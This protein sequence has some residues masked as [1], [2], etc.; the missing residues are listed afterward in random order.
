MIINA[1]VFQIFVGILTIYVSYMRNYYKTEKGTENTGCCKDMC[2]TL[3]CCSIE[4]KLSEEDAEHKKVDTKTAPDYQSM[5]R[6]LSAESD[7]DCIF[8]SVDEN[9][10]ERKFPRIINTDLRETLTK[11]RLT[12]EAKAKTRREL[13][14]EATIALD[15]RENS[16]REELAKMQKKQK[17]VDEDGDDGGDGEEGDEADGENEEET[18]PKLETEKEQWKKLDEEARSI[19]LER[20][21]EE[22]L[23]QKY[24]MEWKA[25]EIERKTIILKKISL[26]QS[27]INYLL[28]FV[29]VLNAFITGFGISDVV[30]ISNSTEAS[31]TPVSKI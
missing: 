24:S 17:D 20:I 9:E 28:Y 7:D 15:I 18:R 21:H 2:E 31:Q 19:R 27:V 11:K 14:R 23:F 4:N 1:L 12:S 22:V 10:L 13:A 8:K 30:G 6:H 5:S 16:F 29:F 25:Q 26:W 3:C